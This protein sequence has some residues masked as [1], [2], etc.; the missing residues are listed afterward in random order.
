M[1]KQVVDTDMIALSANK[2]RAVDVAIN[3]EFSNL[4]SKARSLNDNWKGAAGETAQTT[5][6]QLFTNN[7]YRSY[8]IQN[9]I[10]LLEGLVN[11]GYIAAEDV[12]TK[13]AD[14]FK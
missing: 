2:L 6:Y 5:M 4:Q 12:N 8:V 11:P 10:D 14:K 7:V 13:L 9:Y 3:R 1:T